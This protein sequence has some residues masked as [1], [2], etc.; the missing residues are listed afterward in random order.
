M[1]LAYL[2]TAALA[3]FLSVLIGGAVAIASGV[4]ILAGATLAALI[5]TGRERRLASLNREADQIST[6]QNP[7]ESQSSCSRPVD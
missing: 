3:F 6:E 2:G 5:A 4:F 1:R 7:A